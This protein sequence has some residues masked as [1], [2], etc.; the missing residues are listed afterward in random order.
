MQ[1]RVPP[2]CSNE[3]ECVVLKYGRPKEYDGG[4]FLGRVRHDPVL[5]SCLHVRHGQHLLH[6]LQS[7]YNHWRVHSAFRLDSLKF[8]D[9]L[10]LEDQT[11]M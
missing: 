5:Q 3:V 10:N 8:N 6:L 4:S 7:P 2:V 1:L 9:G 11:T